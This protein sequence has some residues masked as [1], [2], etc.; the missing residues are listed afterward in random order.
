MLRKLC[1]LFLMMIG[2]VAVGKAQLVKEFRTTEKEGFD[3][4]ALEFTSYKSA[5]QLRRTRF[6]DPV[7]IHGHLDKTNI[8]PVFSQKISNRVLQT[9]LIHKNIESENLGKSITSKLFSG[10]SEDFDHSWNVGLST[11]YLY[12]LDFNLGMGR[13]DFDLA[14]LTINQLKVKS[15][16]A[17]VM[18]HYSSDSPN[19]VQMDTLLVTLNMGTVL[20]DK[21][22]FTNAKKMI[23]EVNYG[24]IDLSFSEGMPNASHVIAAVGAGSLHLHLPSD[25][26][27]IRIKMRTTAMCKTSLP[28]YLK[29]LEKGIYVTKGYNAADP[30]LMELIIDVGVGSL[31][32][33]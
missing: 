31:T 21:A 3:M 13:A 1:L 30:R 12:H 26:F 7:Y 29:T 28:K 18:I 4:V 10:S 17:D 11:N 14:S 8:L 2:W 20:V 22:N 6:S 9:S 32:V 25:T 24:K 19:Q 27:P 5:T 16:S 23:F 15:A 33:D